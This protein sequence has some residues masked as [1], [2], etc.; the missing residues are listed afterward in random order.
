MSGKQYSADKTLLRRNLS[1]V[2]V[3]HIPE[4]LWFQAWMQAN[5]TRNQRNSLRPYSNLTR[6][7]EF[8]GVNQIVMK[9]YL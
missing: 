4:Q 3:P 8:K 2:N 1:L 6:E 9:L 5:R 7:E